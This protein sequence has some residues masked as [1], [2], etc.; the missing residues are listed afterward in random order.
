MIEAATQ[1]HA[2]PFW[3]EHTGTQHLAVQDSRLW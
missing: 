1:V 3:T 2:D